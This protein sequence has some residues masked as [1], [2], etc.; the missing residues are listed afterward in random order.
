MSNRYSKDDLEFHEILKALASYSYRKG[1]ELPPNY[2]VLE[3]VDNPKTG[4][5]ADVLSDGNKIVISYRGS[6]NMLKGDG[7][8]NI[9]MARSR[10]PAQA[11]D[12]IK[13]YDKIKEKNPNA[14]IVTTGHSLGGSLSQIVSGI[15]NV[16][17][18]SF[19]AYGTKD[20]FKDPNM[21]KTDKIVNYI[22]ENDTVP[23]AN[24]DNHLGETY[25]IS[26]KKDV[27]NDLFSR[28]KVEALEPLNTRILKTPDELAA[29]KQKLHPN[30]Q[31]AQ[32]VI[33]STSENLN[34]VKANFSDSISSVKTNFDNFGKNIKNVFDTNSYKNNLNSNTSFMDTIKNPLSASKNTILKNTSLVENNASIQNNDFSWGNL[35]TKNLLKS[36]YKG[37]HF[38]NMTPW[39]IEQMLEDLI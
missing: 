13:L 1:N 22:N 17:G 11:T 27:P 12:A 38:D 33:H 36:L 32:N 39:E 4:F 14:N 15:R 3:S 23:M 18:V 25:S 34:K 8:S 26:Q 29:Q 35:T 30:L 24:V 5:Y 2:S 6:D 28:H 37:R 31:G 16:D 7:K 20:L 9:A 10:M 19:N 21:L